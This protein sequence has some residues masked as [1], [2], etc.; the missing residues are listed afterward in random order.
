M[1][2]WLGSVGG[3]LHVNDLCAFVFMSMFVHTCERFCVCLCMPVSV[4]EREN[5]SARQR[6]R[7]E[8]ESFLLLH[9][10]LLIG[11][12]ELRNKI[13]HSNQS[14]FGLCHISLSL[15][16]FPLLHFYSGFPSLK[17]TDPQGGKKLSIHTKIS[18]SP[19]NP[20]KSFLEAAN[21]TGGLQ[22]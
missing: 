22:T 16:L 1:L 14:Q 20:S 11:S 3:S 10:Q 6:D 21:Y 5:D 2:F 19:V 9:W 18:N 13:S 17:W 12:L 4:W 7:Q 8:T 15:Q